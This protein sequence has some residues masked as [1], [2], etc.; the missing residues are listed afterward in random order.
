MNTGK[1][2]QVCYRTEQRDEQVL[3]R[4][5]KN[6]QV[7]YSFGCTSEGETVQVRL[8]DGTLDSWSRRECREASSW[9]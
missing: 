8:V 5:L 4:N 6:G 3:L 7:G 2:E 9:L 1:Y